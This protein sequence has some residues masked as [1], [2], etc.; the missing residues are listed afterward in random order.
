[1]I[2]P[3]QP[4]RPNADPDPR[5]L[6]RVRADGAYGNGPTRKR[7][8]AAGFRMLAPGRGRT[9]RP[10]VGRVRVVDHGPYMDEGKWVFGAV[11]VRVEE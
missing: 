2:R 5:D 3:P 8:A 10:G 4:E 6:P 1:M 9:R 11:E 7:A